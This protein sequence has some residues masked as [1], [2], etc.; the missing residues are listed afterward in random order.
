MAP[1]YG[2]RKRERELDDEEL[3]ELRA[4]IEER[5][6]LEKMLREWDRSKWLWGMI[7][8]GTAWVGGM[9]AVVITF[10]D[11]LSRILKALTQ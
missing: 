11:V 7:G 1:P 10:R 8:K 4:L 2:D 5:K 6:N 9:V 3:R